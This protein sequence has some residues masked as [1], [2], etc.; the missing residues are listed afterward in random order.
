[1]LEG[2]IVRLPIYLINFTNAFEDKLKV[3]S[4]GS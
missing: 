2:K 4:N 3:H 1:M